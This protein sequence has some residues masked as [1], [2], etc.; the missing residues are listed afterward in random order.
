MVAVGRG[1][2]P[3][4][5]V[6]MERLQL[7]PNVLIVVG[8]EKFRRVTITTRRSTGTE[9]KDMM[10]L[11]IGVVTVHLGGVRCFGPMKMAGVQ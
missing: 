6:L 7:P 3:V 10:S 9:E 2:F 11:A 1:A 8:Q 5:V 4:P